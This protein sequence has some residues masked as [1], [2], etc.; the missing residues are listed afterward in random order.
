MVPEEFGG[1][2]LGLNELAV[3]SEVVAARCP[4]TALIMIAHAVA[5]HALSTAGSP[6]LRGRLLNDLAA[7]RLL[8]GFA[9]HELSSGCTTAPIEA[10]ST[11]VGDGFRVT[12]CKP[13]VTAAGHVDAFVLLANLDQTGSS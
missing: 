5:C 13:F 7:G 4:S 11:R 3:A 8:A 1:A 10:R 9:V 6:E 2:G 12:A